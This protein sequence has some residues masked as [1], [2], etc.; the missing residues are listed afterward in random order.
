MAQ[1]EPR[2]GVVSLGTL[3][4]GH[5]A[6]AMSQS[7]NSRL[8]TIIPC[9]LGPACWLWDF[10]RRSKQVGCLSLPLPECSPG[11]CLGLGWVND[12]FLWGSISELARGQMGEAFF[13]A[14]GLWSCR[15]LVC[16][17]C[18][19]GEAAQ[20]PEQ[21]LL[22]FR[23]PLSCTWCICPPQGWLLSPAFL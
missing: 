9:S 6:G 10:L 5:C 4:Q 7:Y 3:M 23:K 20:D 2:P 22:T 11:W 15:E 1:E 16:A 17:Y 21:R 18:R 12:V 13:E 8:N 19:A 14:G